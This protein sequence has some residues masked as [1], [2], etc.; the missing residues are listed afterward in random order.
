MKKSTST[1]IKI[2]KDQQH[3]DEKKEVVNISV[4]VVT[5]VENK[6]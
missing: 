6:V 2:Q 4:I 3:R 1:Y 5:T